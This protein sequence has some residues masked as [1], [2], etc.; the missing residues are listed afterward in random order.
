MSSKN[1]KAYSLRRRM[2]M[3]ITAAASLFAVIA[4]AMI[5]AV[6]WRYLTN[7]V[8]NRLEGMTTDLQN[9]YRQ[10][11]GATP[12]FIRCM[13]EDA[14]EHNIENTFI[15]L[16]T[17]D[18]HPLQNTPMTE[19]MRDRILRAVK[20]GRRE[21][22]FYDEHVKPQAG[23]VAVRLKTAPLYDGTLITVGY[24]ITAVERYLLFL[25]I[26]LGTSTLMVIFGAL[27]SS[28]IFAS[29]FLKRFQEIATAAAAIEAGDL[30]RRVRSDGSAMRSHEV[31]SLVD[32]FNG[33]CD[34][35]E[36][37]LQEM[38]ILTDNIAHDLRTPLTRLAMAAENA[39]TGGHLK[40]P[41]PDLV[42]DETASMLELI[43]TMLE[44][45]QTDI[46]IDHSP[47]D[48]IDLSSLIRQIAD[49]YQPLTEHAGLTLTLTLPEG[50][51][52]FSGHKAKLQQM[53][54][55]LVENAVKYT[56][57]G[58]RIAITLKSTDDAI[59]LMVSDTGCGISE[60]DLPHIFKRFWRADASRT[61]PGNGL[62]LALVKAIVTSYGG[63][64][65]CSS[66]PA[67][68][69]DFTVTLPRDAA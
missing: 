65:V 9:E 43:N 2:V 30:S 19:R 16:S 15:I 54:G 64:I 36:H 56:P 1:A 63:T 39:A 23:H 28:H 58:G 48:E 20:Q 59:V 52:L 41:L 7:T 67:R 45:S 50:S 10:F 61:L 29:R 6:S 44:I 34:K 69:S 66:S 27:I 21:H 57:R 46:K 4:A 35:N 47:R 42:A 37:T 25:A 13:E 3:A 5:F 33:M 8:L 53:L 51:V 22:R 26:T 14:E 49:I 40:A 62:G 55:N 17:A 31:R 32:A 11:G 60:E 38:R 18:A 12:D 24:D 68:G